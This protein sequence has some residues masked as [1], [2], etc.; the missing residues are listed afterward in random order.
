MYGQIIPRYC[1]EEVAVAKSKSVC[2][3]PL[4]GCLSCDR[5]SL[6][7]SGCHDAW[8][9]ARLCWTVADDVSE[10]ISHYLV[11]TCYPADTVRTVSTDSSEADV[12]SKSDAA[13][14]AA[15]DDAVSNTAEIIDST[16]MPGSDGGHTDISCDK[17]CKIVNLNA[18]DG[19]PPSKISRQEDQCSA[20]SKSAATSEAV[21]FSAA[22]IGLRD[23]TVSLDDDSRVDDFKLSRDVS[24]SISVDVNSS[25]SGRPAEVSR[26]SSDTNTCSV[27]RCLGLTPVTSFT[28]EYKNLL[29]H[30]SN[31]SVQPVLYSGTVLPHVSVVIK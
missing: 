14:L 15:S 29:N 13:G 31:F 4:K 26:D 6:P 12:C 27:W 24:E 7:G 3:A 9:K 19:G 17:A 20:A 21:V 2:S 5:G 11:W 1:T 30:H 28:I 23:G 10:T 18:T 22:Q 8:V 16:V 25:D